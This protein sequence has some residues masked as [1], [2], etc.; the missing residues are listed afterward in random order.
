MH[1]ADLYKPMQ[2]YALY[3]NAKFCTEDPGFGVPLYRPWCH[4]LRLVSQ[5]MKMMAGT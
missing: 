5:T 3:E 4:H 1:P 2:K